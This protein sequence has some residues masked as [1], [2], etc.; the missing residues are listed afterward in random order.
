M[1][2]VSRWLAEQGL[3]HHSETF[4]QNRIAGDI[5]CELTDA[6]LR[7]LGLNLGNR[8]RLLKALAILEAGHKQ[9][10]AEAALTRS[11]SRRV[12]AKPNVVS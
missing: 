4:T 1:V 11:P 9:V 5:L 2:D 3:G 6:D 8:K 10:R 7:E 12:L